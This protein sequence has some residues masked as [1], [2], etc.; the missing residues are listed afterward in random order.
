[1]QQRGRGIQKG[2]PP[3]LGGTHLGQLWVATK[4]QGTDN[5]P[6]ADTV[7]SFQAL[8]ISEMKLTPEI[9]ATQ[10]DP[11]Q[12]APPELAVETPEGE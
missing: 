1:M 10:S 5:N 11:I 7:P 12:Q 2:L 8:C 9:L 4:S 3:Y 6:Q